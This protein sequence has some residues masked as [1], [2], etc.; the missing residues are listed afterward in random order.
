MNAIAAQVPD[1]NAKVHPFRVTVPEAE[2]VDLRRRIQATRWPE[3]ET[4]SDESQGVR[5]AMMQD[6]ASYWATDYDW[7]VGRVTIEH[8]SAVCH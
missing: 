8:V 4:I 2:L 6:L 1:E 7:R 5:L 3:R